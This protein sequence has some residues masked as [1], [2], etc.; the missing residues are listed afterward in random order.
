MWCMRL[1]PFDSLQSVHNIKIKLWELAVECL[2]VELD[3]G[4]Q[5]LQVVV[6]DCDG[7]ELEEKH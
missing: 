3:G 4:Q 2:M 7:H 6:G 5:V 1:S